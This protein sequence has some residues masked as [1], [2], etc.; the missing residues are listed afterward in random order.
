MVAEGFSTGRI[1][2]DLG[3]SKSSTKRIRRQAHDNPENFLLWGFVVRWKVDSGTKYFCRYCAW[4]ESKP[5]ASGDHAH[6]HIWDS[7]ELRIAPRP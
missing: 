2:L 3:I 7:S 5:V 4:V 6:G 1:A